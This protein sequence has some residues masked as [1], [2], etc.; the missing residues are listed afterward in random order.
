MGFPINEEVKGYN[1]L[2]YCNGLGSRWINHILGGKIILA[3]VYL[4]HSI[5]KL[6]EHTSFVNSCSPA[7]RGPD[8]LVS[9]GDDGCV[10]L[11]DL[12]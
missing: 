2:Y 5:K 7:R 10:K 8:M 1:I 6:K 3:I 12:R 9:G 4:K 11:W